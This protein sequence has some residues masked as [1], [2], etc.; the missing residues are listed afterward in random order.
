MVANL[1]VIYKCP[2]GLVDASSPIIM[3]FYIVL[4]NS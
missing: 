4:L 3:V 1:F 2:R